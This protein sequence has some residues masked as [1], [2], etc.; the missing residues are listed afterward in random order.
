MHPETKQPD[1]KQP[2][3]TLIQPPL[4]PIG[5]RVTKKHLIDA[6]K[7]VEKREFCEEVDYLRSLGGEKFL[8]SALL[9]D[10][11][12]GLEEVGMSD[13]GH[14]FG[15]NRIPSE[16]I[17]RNFFQLMFDALE[18]FTL[19]ILIVVSLVSIIINLIVGNQD[20]K[21]A[22]IEG[23]TV[24]VAVLISSFVQALNDFQKQKQFERMEFI[25][26]SRKAATVIRNRKKK[27][28][29]PSELLVG[30][31]VIIEAGDEI[32][33]DGLLISCRDIITDESPI[34][35]I[36]QKIRKGTMAQ[37]LAQKNQIEEDGA[38][39]NVKPHDVVSPILLNKSLV[40]SGEGKFV[41]LA[42]GDSATKS[43]I[44]TD[45]QA[46][47]LQFKLE[48]IAGDIGKL[49]L[50]A[51][52][53]TLISLIIRFLVERGKTGTFDEASEYTQLI[54]F[55]ILAITVLVVAIPEGLPLAVT[56]SL[57]F[58][59]RRMLRD[60]N[61]VRK[62]Q[63]CESMGRADMICSDK[64]GT[65]TLNKSTLLRIWNGKEIN[66]ESFIEG[67]RRLDEFMPKKPSKLL[68]EAIVCNSTATLRPNI[69]P[70]IEL[71]LLDFLDQCY[72]DIDSARKKQLPDHPLRLHFTS[73]RKR[74]CTVAINTGLP[75]DL[76]RLHMKGATEIVLDCC[77]F[78]YDFEK[79]EVVLIDEQMKEDIKRAA[80]QMADTSLRTIALAYK[81][82]S[83]KED[84][85]SRDSKN[86]YNIE[87]NNFVL[88]AILGMKDPIKPDIKD[89]VA[90]CRKAGI[91][92]RMV[93]GD[94]KDT[95][96]AM[97]IE[98]GIVD[99]NN[100]ESLVLEGSQLQEIIGGIVCKNC[101]TKEC[102]CPK[103]RITALKLHKDMRED[104][105]E[106]SEEFA[107]IYHRID[108]LARTRPEDKY[109]LVVG[110]KQFNHVVAVT[111]DGITDVQALKKADV[112]FAMGNSG[113][114]I[115]RETAD[116]IV[117]DDHFAS[118]VKAVLWGRNIYDSVKK[119]LQFQLTVNVV[120]V[121]MTLI[122]SALLK[123][124][125][126]SPVQLLWVNLIM[127]IFASLILSTERP[128]RKLINR[129][130]HKMD[131]Y[132]ISRK[133]M[134]FII[135][136]SSY[137]L[138]V[139]LVLVF[140]GDQFIP[141]P[142][143]NIIS[144]GV[145]LYHNS[146][147]GN[148]VRS[149]RLYTID[150]SVDY[151]QFYDL[152][153]ASRHFTVVFNTFVMMQIFNIFNARKL[154][155]E[156]NIITDIWKSKLLLVFLPCIIGLQIV[157]TQL[158]GRALKVSL[159]GASGEQW[160][161]SIAFGFGEWVVGFLLKFIPERYFK[162]AGRGEYKQPPIKKTESGDAP[163]HLEEQQ[164]L[165]R[166]HDGLLSPKEQASAELIRFNQA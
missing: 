94:G 101:R 95:S 78:F 130:P 28:V 50:L 118:V 109:A 19:K 76:K 79:D 67:G 163:V 3:K 25:A 93:T 56:L 155:D 37:A 68:V 2:V 5:F 145:D 128:E 154:E 114:E 148:Y 123:M 62:T 158:G 107:K 137:Q 125:V 53:L 159:D 111:G 34:T 1:V 57:A 74:M 59:V 63:S 138:I 44:K 144:T 141:E 132:I 142:L 166:V 51:A 6:V 49:G 92:V 38:R 83:G 90:N 22:W 17:T 15:W 121:L 45:I 16:G 64:T 140:A 55:F 80:K 86:I 160:G 32:P 54:D 105:L 98:C 35:G 150:G 152:Y 106:K 87:K 30:D 117:L 4:Q 23:F 29:H 66:V 40:L 89:A 100:P 7:K 119:F 69:G 156:K 11:E 84:F 104:V 33:A 88:L 91:K 157:F 147:G 71:C 77:A 24:L 116:I 8:E 41:V 12:H 133:M 113:H 96:R 58:S 127:D 21:I 112:G 135:V 139:M 18:D 136:H 20:R 110:L 153:G 129:N 97:A 162:E 27:S 149:G 122:G 39:N 9:T 46:T 43:Q 143:S 31:I 61:L 164:P 75:N 151:Q 48:I 47:P 124:A 85:K 42:V 81:E 146:P 73:E 70:Q 52:V 131:E 165:Q 161:I 102:D 103:D 36:S 134:R 14:V 115:A 13:R 72:I 10:F 65:L 26:D 126:L 99:P 108:V 120:A 82:V 60:S